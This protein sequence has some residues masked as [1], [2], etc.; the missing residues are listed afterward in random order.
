MKMKCIEKRDAPLR[1]KGT[2]TQPTQMTCT[3]WK[4]RI[5]KPDTTN[6]HIGENK[7]ETLENHDANCIPKKCAI[8]ISAQRELKFTLNP[9]QS[10]III[11]PRK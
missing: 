2:N 1:L 9:Q 6:T 3:T 10:T 4:R 5:T 7:L 8:L 11:K